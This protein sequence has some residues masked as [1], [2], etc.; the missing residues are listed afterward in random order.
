MKLVQTKSKEIKILRT[1][2]KGQERYRK[3]LKNIR[4]RYSKNKKQK[5]DKKYIE[6]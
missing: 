2:V 3:K 4:V 1:Q 6:N 5:N